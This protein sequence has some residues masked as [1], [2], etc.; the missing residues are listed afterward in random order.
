[1]ISRE[2]A[3]SASTQVDWLGPDR[4]LPLPS[5]L[6]FMYTNSDDA[7]TE[8]CTQKADGTAEG[9]ELH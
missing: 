6:L 5:G 2:S 7:T 8:N 1:M 3:M 4:K 9:Y